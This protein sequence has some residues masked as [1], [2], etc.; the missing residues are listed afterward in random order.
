[1][2]R[3]VIEPFA[4]GTIQHGKHNDRIYLMKVGSNGADTLPRAL[5]DLARQRGYSKVFAK[6]PTERAGAF[7]DCGYHCEA[8]IPGFYGADR[9]A[10]MLACFLDESR[11][12]S[13]TAD[14]N[15]QVMDACRRKR[16]QTVHV[17]VPRE[18]TL[19]VCTA[20]DAST[21]S[22]LYRR[23]FETYPFPID[24]PA[25]IRRTMAENVIYFGIQ[26]GGELAAVSSA[27]MDL[28]ARN[29]EMT[30]FATRPACRGRRLATVLLD[31]MEAQVL[32]RGIVTSYT[33]ARAT[34]FGMN[35]T[36]A[37]LG[38]EFGGRLVNNT[39]IAGTFEDMNVWYK[40]LTS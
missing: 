27:E 35:I 19:R 3:D 14:T 6:V 1:M 30:D 22:A 8:S 2:P 31:A 15:E 5:K 10:S 26:L 36:F 28:D 24:D 25:Y 34:S 17:P 38:Y 9:A 23:V 40:R 18:A 39:H 4:G 20:E 13:K 29:A 33:I 32:A 37:T 7:L 21:L 11:S 12:R 16:T